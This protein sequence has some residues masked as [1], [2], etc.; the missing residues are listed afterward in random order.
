[1][2]ALRLLQN[3]SIALTR[4]I[5]RLLRRVPLP[6]PDPRYLLGPALVH[7]RQAPLGASPGRADRTTPN[8]HE[9]RIRVRAPQDAQGDPAA[10]LDTHLES[11]VVQVSVR[12]DHLRRDRASVD[13][14]LY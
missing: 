14:R 13:S 8:R 5:V 7:R 6:V 12:L 2:I 10:A 11:N 9:D 4:V 3:R 1:S